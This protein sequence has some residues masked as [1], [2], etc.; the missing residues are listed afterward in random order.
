MAGFV[1][2]GVDADTIGKLYT[3]NGVAFKA[4][5]EGVVDSNVK[6]PR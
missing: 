4:L 1:I 3:D 6:A 5:G 2:A